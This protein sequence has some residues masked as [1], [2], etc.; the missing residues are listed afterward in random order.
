M[1]PPFRLDR[2]GERLYRDGDVVH[3][4]RKSYALLAHLAERPGELVT[5][6]S[7]L[8]SLWPGTYVSD[9]VL[10]VCVREIRQ[11]LGDDVAPPRFIETAH[12]R[13]YRFIAPVQASGRVGISRS[14]SCSVPVSTAAAA[15]RLVGRDDQLRW[16]AALVDRAAAGERQLALISGEP[17]IGKTALASGFVD[18]LSLDRRIVVARAQCVEHHGQAE[19]Y[20]P[21]FEALTRLAA[22]EA[23]D[24]V[25]EVISRLAPSWIAQLP[26]LVEPARRAR[27]R[28]VL[29]VTSRPRMLREMADALEALSRDTLLVIVLDDLHWSDPSSLDLFAHV[30]RRPDVARLM[31]IGLYRSTDAADGRQPLRAVLQE[32]HARRCC[33]ERRLTLLT[34]ADLA[35]YISAVAVESDTGP[36]VDLLY[37]STEGNPL[38]VMSLLQELRAQDLLFEADGRL[39]LRSSAAAQR[40]LLPESLRH[41]VDRQFERLEPDEQQLLEIAAIVGHEWDSQVVAGILGAE[42]ADVAHRADTLAA[43]QVFIRELV[44][45][46]GNFR[47]SRYA[48]QH[49]IYQDALY[50]R[51]SNA[52][53]QSLHAR[54]AETLDREQPTGGHAPGELAR[55]FEQGGHPDRAIAAYTAGAV[56]SMHRYAIREADTQIQRALALLPEIADSRA[57][58]EHELRLRL[59]EGVHLAAARG[60]AAPETARCYE[61]AQQL[62]D[63]I[64]DERQRFGAHLG[65]WATAL[66]GARLER[67]AILAETLVA[68]AHGGLDAVERMQAHWT[69][70]VTA[71]NRGDTAAALAHFNAAIAVSP[72][73][74]AT[75]QIEHFGHDANVTCRGFAAWALWM[76]GWLRQSRE[77]ALEAVNLAEASRHPHTLAFAYFF[78]AF[79][80]SLRREAEPT[81]EWAQRTVAL[82]EEHALAQWL[83]FGRILRGWARGVLDPRSTGAEDLSEALSRYRDTG[84]E[85]SRPHFL[86]LHAEVVALRGESHQALVILDEAITIARR[87]EEIYYLPELLRLRG[88]LVLADRSIESNAETTAAALLEEA[89]ATARGHR[90]RVFELRAAVDLI[91]LT[92]R[93]GRRGSNAARA[94]VRACLRGLPEP[95]ASPDTTAA[96]ELLGLG[97]EPTDGSA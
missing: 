27:L 58:E 51:L 44:R 90:A 30:A 71:V 32:L 74:G 24:R 40:R 73:P 70:E 8:E 2:V 55:H 29:A 6:A 60:H 16:L 48:F 5:K 7:L 28:D 1:F 61:R 37:R 88:S 83:A 66:V 84:A 89:L 47:R 10:K 46:G 19:A 53:R 14:P 22:G 43:R 57:R 69:A 50:Q 68:L 4:R 77:V 25:R 85:I 65:L 34:E 38:F 62:A 87:T 35:A 20:L 49:S 80:Y 82:G 79:V 21:W 78:N 86:G 64:G 94:R 42:P 3:L 41:L 97:M 72:P 23:G 39:R 75:T 13:G 91:R 76:E 45:E 52:R 67:A 93:S 95:E 36:L 15:C 11:A 63:R 26:S 9:T 12:R 17:G 54:V 18:R 33:E 59:L 31:L 81:L 92:R 56:Q 96:F